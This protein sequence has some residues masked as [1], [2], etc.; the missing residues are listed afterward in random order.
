V[1][2]FFPRRIA[3]HDLDSDVS[4]NSISAANI[5]RN[6]TSLLFPG[7]RAIARQRLTARWGIEVLRRNRYLAFRS[8]CLA[9]SAIFPTKPLWLTRD[10]N[11]A[12]PHGKVY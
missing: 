5:P 1:L 9:S 3:R 4:P 2:H 6:I 11:G 8:P 12:A 10:R 7:N